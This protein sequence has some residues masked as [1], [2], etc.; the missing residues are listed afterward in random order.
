[1]KDIA[2]RMWGTPTARDEQRSVEAS[3]AAKEAFGRGEVT[4]LNTQSKMWATPRASEAHRGTDPKHGTGGPSL[5][6]QTGTHGLRSEAT[7]T[8]G[9][10]GSP[11]VDLNPF[12]VASLMGLPMDWLTLST[13]EATDWCRRQ[14]HTPSEACSSVADGS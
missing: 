14:L 5:R 4:S 8:D 10:A 7:T 1:M 2:V 6:Q 12:F 3:I 11:K 9:D 13:S